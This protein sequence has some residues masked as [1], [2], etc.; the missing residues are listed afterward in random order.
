MQLTPRRLRARWRDEEGVTI[1]LMAFLLVAL[2][3]SAGI[4]VD[5]AL[6]RAD[7][8]QN[9]SAADVAVAAG[10]RAF[11]YHGV[12]APFQGACSALDY[13]KTNHKSLSTL[14]LSSGWTDGNGSA[15]S[16]NPCDSSPSAA[17]I[18]RYN[19]TCSKATAGDARASFAWFR[20][21]SS[22]GAVDITVKA[23]YASSDMV[24]DGFRD[25]Y[26]NTNNPDSGQYGCDQLAVIIS[27]RENVTFGRVLGASTVSSRIRSVGRVTVGTDSSAPIGL[28]LLERNDCAALDIGGFGSVHVLGTGLVSGIAHADSY[29]NASGL[30]SSCSAKAVFNGRHSNGIVAERAP[31]GTPQ[32]PGII[33]TAA[34]NGL[35]GVASKAYD[36]TVNVVAQDSVPTGHA[37]IGRGPVDSAYR[38]PISNLKAD[39]ETKTT[40]SDAQA[41]TAGFRVTN[42]NPNAAD[43]AFAKIFIR[44]GTYNNATTFPA[45]VTDV[46]F[47]GKISEG[48]SNLLTFVSP[49]TVY[50][51]GDS[52]GGTPQ[53]L[54]LASGA[55]LSVN[56]GASAS[57]TSRTTAV[58]AATTKLVISH[59]N[60][61]MTGNSNFALCSTTLLMGDG[62][63]PSTNA[64]APA[65]NSYKGE[66]A[67][68][69]GG[70]IDW[71]APNTN[72]NSLATATQLANLED[73]AFWTETSDQSNI[74]G[75][76]STLSLSG[77][78]FAPN[79]HPFAIDA[80][81]GTIVA[82]A[83]FIVRY[84]SVTG[85]GALSLRANP[86]NV[87]LVPYV[88]GFRLV[89]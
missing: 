27:Q 30:G 71:T 70:S 80:G 85:G 3:G 14:S 61:N 63:I 11:N 28:L 43:L 36:S 72:P 41:T 84:L 7:R 1:V 76:G 9:K 8:Q 67:I 54:S 49:S 32:A 23:G 13:L 55:T 33:S 64:T 6:V 39:A 35:P 29:G 40:W 86:N 47:T 58:P 65:D 82:D 46:V 56:K 50:V 83:Q 87:V 77:V 26:Y 73:L 31:S 24:S 15:I 45:N 19:Q 57:C 89:R 42:C 25:D 20:G 88:N 79:A 74:N 18:A 37:A 59:G 16:G 51:Y 21:T 48:S 22:D 69:G 5:L 44:C 53:G 34:L 38:I 10:V 66:V 81:S 4:V 62:S 68:G 12:V 17:Y 75:S 78:F 60:L 52:S 2:L